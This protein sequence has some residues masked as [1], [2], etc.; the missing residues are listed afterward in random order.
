M[1]SILYVEPTPHDSGMEKIL[2]GQDAVLYQTGKWEVVSEIA[3]NSKGELAVVTKKDPSQCALCH[4]PDDPITPVNR[5]LILRKRGKKY[6][7]IQSKKMKGEKKI[8]K[9]KWLDDGGIGF[10]VNGK[11]HELTVEE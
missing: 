8:S 9:L 10:E 5:I 4:P 2:D 11:H 7:L 3:V 6:H 1:K